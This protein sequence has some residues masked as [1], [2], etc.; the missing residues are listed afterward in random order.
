MHGMA[1]VKAPAILEGYTGKLG[2]LVFR[3]SPYGTQLLER[4]RPKQ[5]N[6]PAQI[7]A[8]NRL[9]RA[10]EA[11]RSMTFEQAAE[12]RAYADTLGRDARGFR[13]E[14][15]NVFS[16]LAM[17]VLQVNPAAQ[18]PFRRPRRRFRVTRLPRLC[19][20]VRGRLS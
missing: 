20:P 5:P 4:Q 10:S 13:M 17:R 8:R 3:Q 6:T 1:T 16:K 12:W 14:A 15:N 18:I 11:W 19:Q 7:A 2:S 9:K